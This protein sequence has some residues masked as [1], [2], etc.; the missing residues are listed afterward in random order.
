MS[1]NVELLEQSFE[2]VKSRADEFAASFYENLFTAHPEMKPLFATTDMAKQQKK[3]INALVLV[4]E[5]LRNPDA[6]GEVLKALGGRHIGYGATAKHYGPVGEALLVSLEQYLQEDWTPE[7]KLAWVNAYRAITQT[8]LQGA[9]VAHAPEKVETRATSHKQPATAP[10]APAEQ[11]SQSVPDLESKL[12]VEILEQSFE[13]VKLRAD[14][15]AASFY[16]N[17]FTAHPEVKPLFATTDMAKQQKKLINALVLVVES[18]RN[19]DALGEVLKALGGRHIGYGATAKHYGPVGEALLVS[20]EQYL[21]Q[22]WTPEVKLAWVN[23]YRAITQTMLQGAGEKAQP[24]VVRDETATIKKPSELKVERNE[25]K[26][27]QPEIK[28]QKKPLVSIQLDGDIFKEILAK[29]TDSYQ[30][31]Q[32]QLSEQSWSQTIKK[33]PEKVIDTFWTQPVWV[34]A[35]ASAVIMT[36]VLVIADENS[37]LFSTCYARSTIKMP[38]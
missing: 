36:V 34:V 22:D 14:E 15:F 8:M 24:T 38:I 4:V 12:P 13:K 25:Y 16:E 32:T 10:T 7:V 6:L 26:P 9:G 29:V 1:L 33:I 18:L 11:K 19:P 17:L 21:Q 27:F 28:P 20:L 5:S 30:Q 23:A 2:K 35:T 37:W 31:F 3:L